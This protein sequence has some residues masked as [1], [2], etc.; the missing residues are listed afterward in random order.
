MNPR[1][2]MAI[3]E[4]SCAVSMGAKCR[5]HKKPGLLRRVQYHSRRC[6]RP[7][8][9]SRTRAMVL[10]VGEQHRHDLRLLDLRLVPVR[11]L[12][13]RIGRELIASPRPTLRP[14]S[15]YYKSKTSP[16]R[17][18]D[19]RAQIPPLL[20]HKS[21]CRRAGHDRYHFAIRSLE[22]SKKR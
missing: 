3:L 14:R 22:R 5:R 16:L 4:Q 6:R 19:R 2:R 12:P 17:V 13:P 15:A 20:A 8:R 11:Q 21:R 1:R 18:D 9:S 10:A 7:Q